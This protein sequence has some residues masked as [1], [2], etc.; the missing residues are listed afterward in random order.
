MESG[1]GFDAGASHEGVSRINLLVIG[2]GRVITL[3]ASV[4][5][6][7]RFHSHNICSDLASRFVAR[8]CLGS[9][10]GL[11]KV[12]GISL[13]PLP[14]LGAPNSFIFQSIVCFHIDIYK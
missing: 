4:I 9:L 2:T 14:T 7:F 10:L 12:P 11:E 3:L 1:R 6:T 13:S 5:P 8:D